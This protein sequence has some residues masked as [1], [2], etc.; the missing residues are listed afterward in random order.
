MHVMPLRRPKHVQSTLGKA[1][2]Q[3]FLQL[4]LE[5][6]LG[7]VMKPYIAQGPQTSSITSFS[8]NSQWQSGPRHV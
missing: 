7:P 5:S 2:E 3:M 8:K 1:G 6:V 4:S